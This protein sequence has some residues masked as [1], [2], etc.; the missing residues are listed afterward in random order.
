MNS[1]NP[2]LAHT[3]TTLL[4]GYTYRAQ[5]A[6]RRSINLSNQEIISSIGTTLCSVC[7][8]SK[9]HFVDRP[10]VQDPT[11]DNDKSY[12]YLNSSNLAVYLDENPDVKAIALNI[13]GTVC[14]LYVGKKMLNGYHRA[15]KTITT[16]RQ[17]TNTWKQHNQ[18]EKDYV[19]ERA[20]L[21]RQHWLTH[22][23]KSE[24]I[25]DH[26][27]NMLRESF[28]SGRIELLR[29]ACTFWK[30]VPQL[31][32]SHNFDEISTLLRGMK[33]AVPICNKLMVTLDNQVCLITDNDRQK[34][35]DWA[36]NFRAIY[37]LV[38]P[39]I[40]GFSTMA[41]GKSIGTFFGC[42]REGHIPLTFVQAKWFLGAPHYTKEELALLNPWLAS[43]KTDASARL[44]HDAFLEIFGTEQQKTMFN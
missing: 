3:L 32:T 37:T 29:L 38:N 12:L 17:L 4:R 35:L 33:T 7:L 30:R 40:Y 26:F 24:L 36:V 2:S 20:R 41:S 23:F 8:F 28:D 25:C 16:N 9:A 6:W 11:Y 22:P 13:L 1:I 15:Q 42:D 34:H 10:S 27:F 5:S 18:E 44:E 39:K 21:N 19:L 14:M 31:R 43:I